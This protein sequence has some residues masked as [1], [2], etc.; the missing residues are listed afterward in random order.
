MSGREPFV[1]FIPIE[2]ALSGPRLVLFDQESPDETVGRFDTGED[3]DHPLPS[4]DLLVQ[5]LLHVGRAQPP[6]VL[7]GK[8][9]HAHG[10]LEALLETGD[11][12]GGDLPKAR[13]EG[14]Q[15]PA[16]L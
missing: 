7:L 16:S 8:H 11:G 10:V 13:D 15:L 14:G 6:A 4:A 9:H 2:V 3:P 12:L 1:K 5:A